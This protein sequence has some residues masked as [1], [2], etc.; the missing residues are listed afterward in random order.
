MYVLLSP[1]KRL[2]AQPAPDGVSLTKPQLM[3]HTKDLAERAQKFTRADLKRLMNISDDLAD[4]NYQRFQAFSTGL[5]GATA[6]ALT[7][8]GDV[9]QGLKAETLSADDLAFAQDHIGILSGLY[10]LLR[11]AIITL[12]L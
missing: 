4:L 12:P 9:Y 6:A 11:P 5:K 7:F 10:G 2:S 1:A 3:K 8:N